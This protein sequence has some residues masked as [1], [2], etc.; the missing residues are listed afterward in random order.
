MNIDDAEKIAQKILQ[1]EVLDDWSFRFDF[2]KKRFGMCNYSKKEISLSKYL[3]ELNN[4]EKV[5]DTI[6][7]EIAHAIAGYSAGHGKDWKRCVVR[8]GGVPER[9]YSPQEVNTPKLKYTIFCKTCHT[10]TQKNRKFKTSL[11]RSAPACKS[12]CR[13]FNN[14]KFSQKFLLECRENSEKI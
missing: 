7:H 14:G 10:E 2:A 4:E 1:E 6:I 8:M 13:K 5:R 12:C 3:V 11:F 9:C